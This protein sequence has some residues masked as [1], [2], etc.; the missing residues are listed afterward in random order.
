M[1]TIFFNYFYSRLNVK[2]VK[3]FLIL[4]DKT[5]IGVFINF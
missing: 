1:F 5:Y 2:G 4:Y 3:E